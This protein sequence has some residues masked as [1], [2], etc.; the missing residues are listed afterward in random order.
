MVVVSV[1]PSSGL[2]EGVALLSARVPENS[3]SSTPLQTATDM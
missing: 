1:I 3:M 2:L